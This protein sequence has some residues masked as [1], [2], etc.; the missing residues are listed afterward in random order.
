MLSAIPLVSALNC[1][2]CLLNMAG[3]AIGLSLYLKEHP[4]EK[5]SGGEGAISGTISGGV[6]GVIYALLALVMQL[7]LGSIGAGMY[8]N[9][10]GLPPVVLSLLTGGAV[11]FI[12]IPVYIG[13]GALGGFLSMQF[14]F[15]DRLKS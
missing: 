14:I 5:L 11:G 4:D 9:V 10:H 1:C 2:F 12:M 6:A 3:A 8:R 7:A 15:K 13:F